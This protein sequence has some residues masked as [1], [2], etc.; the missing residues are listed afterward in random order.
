MNLSNITEQ[1]RGA[2]PVL[3]RQYN[4]AGLG[5]FGSFARGDAQEK[6]DIDILVEF[7]QVPD[8]FEFIRL[9]DYLSN[10]LG[11]DVDL[12]SKKALKAAIRDTI[13]R[14]AVYV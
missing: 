6:S 11:R 9:K 13:L 1:L 5:V 4:V 7:S 14:E 2:L 10:L 12:V 3:T 8:I